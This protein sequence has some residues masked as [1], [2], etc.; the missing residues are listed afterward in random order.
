[1]K[2]VAGARKKIST[3]T[4]FNLLGP[5]TNPTSRLFQVIGVYEHNKDD[6]HGPSDEGASSRHVL[7]VHGEDGLD[8]IT[9]VARLTRL[10]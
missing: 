3:R 7:L 10:N 1:M 8:E 5:L 2:N 4:I 9:L 6:P